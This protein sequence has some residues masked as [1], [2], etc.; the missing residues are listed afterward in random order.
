MKLGERVSP[1]LS[2]L[3]ASWAP[4]APLVPGFD[5]R[6]EH[7]CSLESWLAVLLQRG[8]GVLEYG[9]LETVR[10]QRCIVGDTRGEG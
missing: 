1:V 8:S 5:W 10:E 4:G 6:A 9:T 2:R 3:A 7:T